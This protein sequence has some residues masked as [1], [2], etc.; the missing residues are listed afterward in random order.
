METEC[1][2][3]GDAGIT[4]E[5]II[6]KTYCSENLPPAFAEAA[7]RRQVAPHCPPGQRPSW[8]GGQRGVIP[9]FRKGRE[10]G[11]GC[12]VLYSGL[13]VKG[14]RTPSAFKGALTAPFTTT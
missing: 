5:S 6:K 2:A 1:R 13:G 11:I 12:E 10:G 8:A 9:L 7:S 3:G 4:K 14:I